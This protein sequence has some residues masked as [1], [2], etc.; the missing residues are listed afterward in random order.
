MHGT[1]WI[2]LTPAYIIAGGSLKAT[3]HIKFCKVDLVIPQ[4]V[5]T[6]DGRLSALPAD[7]LSAAVAK[8]VNVWGAEQAATFSRTR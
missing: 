8:W 1:T 5:T 2:G 7:V 6:S 4:V 3:D